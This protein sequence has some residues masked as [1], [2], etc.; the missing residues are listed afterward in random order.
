MQ[1]VIIKAMKL[2]ERHAKVMQRLLE[3]VSRRD[4]A[5]ELDVHETTISLWQRQPEFQSALESLR[6][7]LTDVV[8]EVIGTKLQEE[9][10]TSLAK[11]AH[12]RDK[13]SSEKVQLAASQ[14]I[15]DRAGFKAVD[16]VQSIQ[17]HILSPEFMD[18]IRAVA[19]ELRA[20][21]AGSS[22]ITVL[23]ERAGT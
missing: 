19:Q 4:I 1:D 11:I 2:D 15:L 10:P 23:P 13:A 3:G 14:D 17:M 18:T 8:R 7:D 5:N 9:A 6:R 20:Y 12:L 22:G 16:K 21:S